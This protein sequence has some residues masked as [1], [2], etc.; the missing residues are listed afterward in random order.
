MIIPIGITRTYFELLSGDACH[1]PLQCFQCTGMG[2]LD[3]YG[4]TVCHTRAHAY[5][6]YA[7]GA[8]GQLC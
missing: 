1:L 4:M 7:K 8:S 3:A 5:D 6:T 2:I